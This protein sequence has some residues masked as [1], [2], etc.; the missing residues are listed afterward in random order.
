[1]KIIVQAGGMGTRLEGLT[2]NKPKCLVSVRGLPIIFY[3]FR[4]FP[5]AEFIVIA[6]YKS[7]VL[8]K[9][10]GVFGKQYKYKIVKANKKGTLS[11]IKHALSCINDD[12][13]FMLIWSDLI[14]SAEFT[15]PQEEGNYVGISKDFECRWSYVNN[16]FIQTPSKENGVAGLFLFENKNVLNDI[17]EEGAFVRWLSANNSIKFKR[18]DLYGTKEI[19]TLLAYTD[20]N[21]PQKLCRPFNSIEFK[22]DIVVKKAIDSQGEKIA[23]NEINWYRHVKN[24]GFINIPEIY[25]YTPL[26]MK[27]VNGKNI[28]EYDC[29]SKL[30][31]KEILGNMID[32][33][34]NL[35][36]I[37]PTQKADIDD[38]KTTYI[39]KT[40]DRLEK[41]RDL[42]PFAR[43]EFIKINKRYC[44]NILYFRDEFENAISGFYPTEFRLIHGDCTFSNIM[45]DSFGM[46]T[47]FIDP[48]GYFGNSL[49]YG[50]VDYDWAKLYYSIVG[51]YD[52][53]NLKRFQLCINEKDVDFEINSNNWADM[54]EVFFCSIPD[55]NRT[56][57]KLIHSL[58]W[59]SLTTYAWDDYDS[60][61]G[62]FYNGILKLNEV[63]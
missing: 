28:F 60:I 38:V 59:L 29:L 21:S 39:Y 5:E 52:Q 25:Q 1:M 7:D 36:N 37:E 35:H 34:N 6:D 13:R 48:R 55:V 50:D 40:F 45:F 4:K 47:V 27:R 32:A 58:I 18:L 10:L 11:G 51:N 30:Q 26:V 14:L 20:H 56:K 24:L 2:K 19:G 53:F 23:Q 61:C 16:E 33:L 44:K 63:L 15:F 41:V 54:E 12:E 9:Y 57:I 62:A 8:E 31:K 43:D 42:I 46:K 17:P 3:L 49:L 22:D